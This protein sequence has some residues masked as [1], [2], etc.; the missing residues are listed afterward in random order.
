MPRK[1]SYYKAFELAI[2]ATKFFIV[3]PVTL[4]FD[5]LM[6]FH[7][8]SN[9]VRHIESR[10]MLADTAA[11]P[12]SGT[13]TGFSFKAPSATFGAGQQS[14][15]QN[16]YSPHSTLFQHSSRACVFCDMNT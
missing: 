6:E 16:V 13:G 7:L 11:A 2:V 14:A 8:K 9:S 1:E 10:N 4:H 3:V 12:S 5:I 15:N